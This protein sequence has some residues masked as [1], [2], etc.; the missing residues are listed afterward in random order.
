M[1]WSPVGYFQQWDKVDLAQANCRKSISGL[2]GDD[3]FALRALRASSARKQIEAQRTDIFGSDVSLKIDM[4]AVGAPVAGLRHL[5]VDVLESGS[6]QVVGFNSDDIK[7]VEDSMGRVLKRKKWHED[8][9]LSDLLKVILLSKMIRGRANQPAH[10]T[11]ENQNGKCDFL[12]SRLGVDAAPIGKITTPEIPSIPHG[13]SFALPRNEAQNIW[14]L[15][16]RSDNFDVVVGKAAEKEGDEKPDDLVAVWQSAYLMN[17]YN[18]SSRLQ[19]KLYVPATNAARRIDLKGINPDWDIEISLNEE[20]QDAWCIQESLIPIRLPLRKQIDRYL[21]GFSAQPKRMEELL[22]L[23]KQGKLDLP[24]NK[25]QKPLKK[26]III[27]ELGLDD[28]CFYGSDEFQYGQLSWSSPGQS[29]V[30]IGLGGVGLS[31]MLAA[32]ASGAGCVI[33]VD[34]NDDKL[35]LAR[36]LGAHQTFNAKAD[37]CV[38]SIRA[39]TGGG[40]PIAIGTIAE[41]W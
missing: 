5:V 2:H 15:A 18:R 39:A 1:K 26:N 37:N 31:A 7:V 27:V 17:F 14:K 38:E 41:S 40:V 10:I 28:V 12:I 33:A 6:V 32:I 9:P 25:D 3:K 20:Q 16:R 11:F 35:R 36:Q 24:T 19:A 34:I 22:E 23:Y 21:S 4:T 13:L 29:I 30:I 8:H